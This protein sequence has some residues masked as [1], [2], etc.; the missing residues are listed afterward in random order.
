MFSTFVFGLEQ[1]R[2][3]TDAAALGPAS[4]GAPRHGV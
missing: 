3:Y 4:L 2:P 1:G